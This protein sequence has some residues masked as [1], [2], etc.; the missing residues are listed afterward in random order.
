MNLVSMNNEKTM[1]SREISTLT[2]KR[3][4][5][6]LRDIRVMIADLHGEDAIPN[7]GD[8]YTNEQ[9]GVEYAQYQLPKRE[10]LILVSGYSVKMRAAIIDRWQELESQKAPVLPDFTQPAIAARAWAEQYEKAQSLAI[11][12]KEQAEQLKAAGPALK[13]VAEFVVASGDVSLSQAA[14]EIGQSPQAFNR[15]L[16]E[17]G[18]I[19]KLGNT[20]TAKQ[21]QINAGRMNMKA[22]LCGDGEHRPQCLVTPKGLEYIAKKLVELNQE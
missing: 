12:N 18:I 14:K 6:V 5:H 16:A 3:H 10:S 7:F 21:A 8:T 15:Q 2:G 9:N 19:F 13:F 22:V 1:S 4:D 20:W 17:L 11:E